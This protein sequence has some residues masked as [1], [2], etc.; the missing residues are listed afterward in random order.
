MSSAARPF[1]H[2]TQPRLTIPA[3]SPNSFGDP[4]AG[5]LACGWADGRESAADFQHQHNCTNNMISVPLPIKRPDV[6]TDDLPGKCGRCSQTNFAFAH[7]WAQLLLHQQNPQ[8]SLPIATHKVG[9]VLSVLHL[10]HRF[11][12]PE[13]YG[14]RGCSRGYHRFLIR[15]YPCRT[16]S[17]DGGGWHPQ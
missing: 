4:E 15:R 14:R 2:A 10:I 8:T 13:S 16:P 9:T 3:V 11:E 7:V 17:C 12:S 5:A 1:R 6:R